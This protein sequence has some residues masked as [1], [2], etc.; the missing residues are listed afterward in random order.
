VTLCY[1]IVIIGGGPAGSTVAALVKRYSPHLR[2]LVLERAHFPR[3]HVGE[4]LLAA[5]S[6]VLHEMG[7]YDRI[8]RYGFVEKLGASYVWGH[9]RR[10]WG[11]E[12]AN[13][14][15]ELTKQGRPL[16]KMYTKG[17]HVR[18][19]E[20]DQLLLETAA[21]LG[22]EVRFGAYVNDV[23]IDE[24]SQQVTG[25][26]FLQD[27]Q[28]HI[29]QSKWVIDAS[30]Q[31]GLLGRKFGLRE[32]DE[33]MNNYALWAYWRGAKWE[34]RYLGQ[35][36]L[37]RI[38]VATTPRGWIWYI[39]VDRDV[40]SVGL[41]THRNILRE[42][43]DRP[44]ALYREELSACP[45]VSGLLDG[46]E[47]VRISKDQR[48]DICTIRDWSYNSRRMSGP[49]WALV[50]DAA[51]FVDPILS[52]GVMLAHELGQKA[53]YALN[54]SFRATSD[55]QVRGYWSFYEETY[56]TYLEAYRS[57]AA[58]W[59]TN[60]FSMESWWW[61][62]RRG[63]T[64]A[65]SAVDLSEPE[66]FMR[67]ASG[68]ANRA[69]SLSLFGSYPLH[70]AHVL[71]SGLFGAAP[72]HGPTIERFAD[73][74]LQMRPSA[75]VTNGQYFYGGFVR[76]TRRVVNRDTDQYLDLHPGEDVLVDLLNG[77]HTLADL[78]RMV[79]GIRQA[80]P[81]VPIRTGTELIVQ[82]DSIGALAGTSDVPLSPAH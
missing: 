50:G 63:L 69:E 11:F 15:A 73:R 44:E 64:Q 39:P 65:H 18:R 71:V 2:V 78:N 67:V 47:I 56:K 7:A 27:A 62:A 22:A 32:Y 30:G 29:V 46:A 74:L 31:D 10:P 72:D 20:Y 8:D 68:Y 48:R 36:N 14:I 45:E 55:E 75:T 28:S 79:T 51:G 42:S 54:S 38:F 76:D 81:R 34:M 82:L 61:E 52:S 24:S 6:P 4:S 13:L 9:D 49:G 12:F 5:A 37:A 70:E 41:V 77:S 60:N 43:A 19:A 57:M 3:H 66:A 80:N 23:I 58:F 59:Y 40:M 26:T 33:R 35:P 53:A 1:D 25:V 16:P 17:W 21:E